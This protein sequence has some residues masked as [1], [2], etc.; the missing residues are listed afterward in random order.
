[1]ID[2]NGQ[3]YLIEKIRGGHSRFVQLPEA[4]WSS[5]VHLD[6]VAESTYVFLDTTSNDPQVGVKDVLISDHE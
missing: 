1:M 4:G 2:P 5:L 6:T 3:L